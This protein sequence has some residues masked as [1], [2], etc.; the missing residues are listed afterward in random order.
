[1]ADAAGW[2][3]FTPVTKSVPSG[4]KLYRA[5]APNYVS[6]DSD[7]NLT[8]AAVNFLVTQ[9]IDSIISFNEYEYTAAEKD[10]LAKATPA[11]KYLHLK[12]GDFKPPTLAQF[13]QA[14]TFFLSNK[15]TLVH[16]GYGWGRTGTGITG[17]Q[18]YTENGRNLQPLASS[19]TTL[20]ASGGNNVEKREQ[21]SIL[22]ER[23]NLFFPYVPPSQDERFIYLF[24]DLLLFV[25]GSQV[26]RLAIPSRLSPSSTSRLATT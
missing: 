8:Q 5:S 20:L 24:C 18:I 16:C 15:S 10:R 13:A 25:V 9:A 3:R 26:S 1:M 11:I 12:L 23:R 2:H 7:Q 14:N 22:S 19:W 21:V 6:Q 4:H 17:L